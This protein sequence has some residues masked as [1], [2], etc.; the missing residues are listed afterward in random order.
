MVTSLNEALSSLWIGL[1]TIKEQVQFQDVLT[2]ATQL[3][4]VVVVTDEPCRVSYASNKPNA[5]TESVSYVSQQVV[6]FLRPDLL[7]KQ[8]SIIS[9][10]QNGCTSI[11]KASG[12]PKV[13]SAHQEIPLEIL[14]DKA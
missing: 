10:T 13:Y 1:C 8:G 3:T 6:L 11:Y 2:K 14:D 7:V 4:E 12:A 5:E 9:V